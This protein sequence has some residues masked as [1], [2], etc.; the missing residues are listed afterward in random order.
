[1]GKNVAASQH[2]CFQIVMLAGFAKKKYC[3]TRQIFLFSISIAPHGAGA[4]RICS[5]ARL[6]RNKKT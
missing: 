3:Q 1:M 2:A 4:D 6:A 5:E